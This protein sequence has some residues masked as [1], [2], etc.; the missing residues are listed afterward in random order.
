MSIRIAVLWPIAAALVLCSCASS[1]TLPPAAP[2]SA[3]LDARASASTAGEIEAKL[4]MYL[5]K[6]RTTDHASAVLASVILTNGRTI[7]AA[8]GMTQYGGTTPASPKNLFQIGS[9][10][11]SFTAVAI[12]QLEAQGKLS[13][14]QTLGMW[15]P[16]YPAWKHITIRHLLDMTSGLEDY[17]GTNAWQKA[18]TANPYGY[19]SPEQLIALVD[20][21]VPLDHGWHY[22]NTGYLLLELIIEKASARTYAGVVA[23]DIIPRAHLNAT[24][25]RGNL[26]PAKLLDR[27]VDGYYDLPPNPPI[28]KPFLGKSVRDYSLS[29]AAAAG[30]IVASPHDLAA[31]VHDLY[32]GHILNRAQR[33]ELQSLVST[34]TGKPI[35]RVTAKDPVGFGFGVEAIY[36]GSIG[37]IWAYEGE[38]LGYRTLYLYFPTGDITIAVAVNSA[39]RAS[40]DTTA[41]LAFQV[42][43]ILREHGSSSVAESATVSKRIGDAL[44]TSGGYLAG[45]TFTQRSSQSTIS[46]S[47]VAMDS[48]PR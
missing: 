8:T 14:D 37:T 27:M 39:V 15:L 35:A 23:G 47:T 40:R 20:P 11:K 29:Y 17:L 13:V 36:G 12:L 46:A 31:W 44:K 38:T 25:F 43:E 28:W 45:A 7:D 5:A 48:R 30:G 41:D 4:A 32:R 6:R 18:Y 16:Q 3:A 26:Y 2:N 1:R 22:T 19:L 10:T 21:N 42:Y 33:G 34:T 9:N 24:Y